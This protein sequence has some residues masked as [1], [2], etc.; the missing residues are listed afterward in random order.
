M[1]GLTPILYVLS[2]SLLACTYLSPR[3][4]FL[5]SLFLLP[6]SSHLIRLFHSGTLRFLIRTAGLFTA[7][8]LSV[9]NLVSSSVPI[10]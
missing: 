8:L 3:V 2:R 10:P 7:I 6:G 5:I 1:Y 9:T 4:T